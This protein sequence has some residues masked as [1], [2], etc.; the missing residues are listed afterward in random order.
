VSVVILR[1]LGTFVGGETDILAALWRGFFVSEAV[2]LPLN[3]RARACTHRR[4]SG[5][6]DGAIMSTCAWAS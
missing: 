5:H 2:D 1:G 4:G 3:I 6:R